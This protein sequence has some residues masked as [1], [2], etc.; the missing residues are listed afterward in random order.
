MYIIECK[1]YNIYNMIP[2]SGELKIIAL[3]LLSMSSA[4]GSCLVPNLSL[5]LTI[6]ML[7][8]LVW[9]RHNTMGAELFSSYCVLE[10]S[11]ARVRAI[12]ESVALVNHL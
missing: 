6:L 1:I 3:V 8:C 4:V 10:T 2:W 12:S 5:S 7:F 9:R 11:L